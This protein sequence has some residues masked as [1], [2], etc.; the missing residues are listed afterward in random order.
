[1][2]QRKRS[3]QKFKMEGGKNRYDRKEGQKTEGPSLIWKKADSLSSHMANAIFTFQDT[4]EVL[5][6]FWEK[7]SLTQIDSYVIA[8]AVAGLKR[9]ATGQVYVDMCLN[10]DIIYEVVHKLN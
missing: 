3:Q 4:L 2:V 9:R 10:R 7:G 6:V 1:M 5:S 8:I